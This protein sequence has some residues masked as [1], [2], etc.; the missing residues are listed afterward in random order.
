MCYKFEIIGHTP[1]L[2]FGLLLGTGVNWALGR[3]LTPL[4]LLGLLQ[5]LRWL[6]NHLVHNFLRRGCYTYVYAYDMSNA[7]MICK[8][9]TNHYPKTISNY[10]H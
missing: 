3:V 1:G 9:T 8:L 4:L 6:R 2:A 5:R 7:C 10:L